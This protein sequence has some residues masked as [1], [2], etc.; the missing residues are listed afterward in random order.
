MSR[1]H[2]TMK[3]TT[4]IADPANTRRL[5]EEVEAVGMAFDIPVED[6]NQTEVYL[7]TNRAVAA[8]GVLKSLLT[9]IKLHNHFPY[10]TYVSQKLHAFV[11]STSALHVGW[12][13]FFASGR[14]NLIRLK[15]CCGAHSGVPVLSIFE[16][17][18]VVNI[19][20]E[21]VEFAHLP[22]LLNPQHYVII[23]LIDVEIFQLSYR[24]IHPGTCYHC[25]TAAS[26]PSPLGCC[27][28]LL[29][30]LSSTQ[31]YLSH[32]A[33]RLNALWMTVFLASTAV[34]LALVSIV[35]YESFKEDT[36]NL[37]KLSEGVHSISELQPIGNAQTLT[38][39]IGS[40][41]SGIQSWIPAGPSR[42]TLS[43]VLLPLPFQRFHAIV[44]V[45]WSEVL[46][47][48]QNI[49]EAPRSIFSKSGPLKWRAIQNPAKTVPRGPIY[50]VDLN[51]RMTI[52]ENAVVNRVY[53][54]KENGDVDGLEY[55]LNGHGRFHALA[56]EPSEM[57]H[58]VVFGPEASKAGMVRGRCLALTGCREHLR[59]R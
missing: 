38:A 14:C 57:L 51:A 21:I 11:R 43:G 29:C 53:T 56:N 16:S 42:R 1:K 54:G 50:G 17:H 49:S 46:T 40:S 27:H 44:V 31:H 37:D 41:P 28:M 30:T 18:E 15:A 45:K 2:R 34:L 55:W 8:G 10:T 13:T 33:C 25:S 35:G 5:S 47:L 23:I 26:L 22:K 52:P 59:D 19:G 36:K 39:W 6:A 7:S 9:R 48:F 4:S 3:R 24:R 58:F 32:H 12:F 20:G